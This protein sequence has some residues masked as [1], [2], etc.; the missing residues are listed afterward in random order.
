MTSGYIPPE[1]QPDPDDILAALEK[2]LD[3]DP[4]LSSLSEEDVAQ[5]LVA[6]GYLKEEPS[7]T[8][9]AEALGTIETERGNP[10]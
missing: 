10:T 3:D 9:V 4:G 1:G 6:D 2:A 8:L 5:R 7:P